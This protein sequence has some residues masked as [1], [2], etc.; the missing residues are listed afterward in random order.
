MKALAK[1]PSTE[2]A[3]TMR[4]HFRLGTTDDTAERDVNVFA[5]R[6]QSNAV[7]RRR[8]ESA[9]QVAPGAHAMVAA[10]IATPG[11]ALAPRDVAY[12]G[13]HLG[14]DARS[15]VVH[16]DAP[17]DRA[18]R[19]VGARAFALGAHL[20]FADGAYRP[21]EPA[22]R[23]LL[24]H[25]LVHVA[26]AEAGPTVRRQ[27]DEE[28][29]S[30]AG[31]VI[32]GGLAT[33][34]EQLAEHEPFERL[35]LDPLKARAERE[36]ARLSGL[37][38]GLVIGFG[39]GSY[40]LTL[41]ALLADP[42]GRR[43]LSDINLLAP[44]VLI[45]GWPLTDFRFELP[46]REGDTLDFSLTFDGTRLLEAI[47]GETEAAWLTSFNVDV[48]W[49]VNPTTEAWSLGTLRATIG[50]MPGLTLTG[51]LQPGPF[52]TTPRL[53][54]GPGG[55]M[56]ELRQSLPEPEGAGGAVSRLPNIGGVLMLDLARF[57]PIPED[58]RRILGG[59]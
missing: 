27:E 29:E 44:T 54:F 16:D 5:A 47:R 13:S 38:T 9:G 19:S 18:A 23:R 59:E 6:R 21:T 41:G 39:A 50:I 46:E 34:A 22:G 42:N 48:G 1:R 7:V 33:V 8:T 56:I 28:G 51:G 36:F 35:V 53:E 17:A 57:R 3:V 49:S 31:E 24:A 20:V 2:A 12:F 14:I 32:A 25:E 55:E 43:I 10:A 58:I 45:P 15:V 30:R 37:E 4:P 40:A 11:Q 26:Q 52:L